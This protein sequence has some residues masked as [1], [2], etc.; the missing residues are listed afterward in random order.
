MSDASYWIYL[1][2]LPIVVFFQAMLISFD[3]NPLFKF[4]IVLSC[5]SIIV[6]LTYNYMVRNTLIGKF[7]NGRKYPPGLPNARQEG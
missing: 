1:V 6:L 5:T 4:L 7:L 2:H 3:I